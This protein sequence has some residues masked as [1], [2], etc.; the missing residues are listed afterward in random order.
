MRAEIGKLN[1]APTPL[2]TNGTLVGLFLGKL[3]EAFR[4]LLINNLQTKLVRTAPAPGAALITRHDEDPF[5][6]EEVFEMAT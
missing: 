1:K 3:E 6:I 5:T 4:L 2:C